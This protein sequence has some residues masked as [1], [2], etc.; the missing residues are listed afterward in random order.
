ME[1]IR[2][3]K[4]TK[5]IL[6]K[7]GQK[8]KKIYIARNLFQQISNDKRIKIKKDKDGNFTYTGIPL[9][10]VDNPFSTAVKMNH[11]DWITDKLNDS[12]LRLKFEVN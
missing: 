3:I 1:I 2:E 6:K 5:K 9:I 11:G 12:T 8:I 4:N 7:N 10:I